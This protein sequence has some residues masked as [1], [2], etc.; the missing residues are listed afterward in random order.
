MTTEEKIA[1]MQAHV[2]GKRIEWKN[3]LIEWEILHSKNPNWDW[4]T[5]EYRIA[6]EPKKK[7]SDE[8]WTDDG[9]S[10]EKEL[11]SL[12]NK[13]SVENLADMPDFILSELICALI[14]TIGTSVKENLDWHGCNSVCHPAK[15]PATLDDAVICKPEEPKL[16]PWTAE[17]APFPLALRKKGWEPGVYLLG[18]AT[19]ITNGVRVTGFDG[20][21]HYIKYEDLAGEYSQWEQR[22]GSPC[23]EV[24]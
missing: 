5:C 2:D 14:T 18:E 3:E 21:I 1:V 11:A 9:E 12:I 22:D 13:Y 19:A 8:P 6:E 10:F 4:T 7:L 20:K 15:K 23:G 24:K 16:I 17:T